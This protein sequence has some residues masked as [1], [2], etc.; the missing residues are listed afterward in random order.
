MDAVA[1]TVLDLIVSAEPAPSVINVVHPHPV[2]WSTI[3]SGVKS[4]LRSPIPFVTFR[5]WLAKL[6]VV[7]QQP[8]P[9]QLEAVVS[10]FI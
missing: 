10:A 9:T 1:G 5:E 6:E 3:F 8:T 2:P 7:A 4:A